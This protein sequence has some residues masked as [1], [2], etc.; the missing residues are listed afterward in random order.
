MELHRKRWT[1]ERQYGGLLGDEMAIV[2]CRYDMI[3]ILIVCFILL[4]PSKLWWSEEMED[5]GSRGKLTMP[6]VLAA[7]DRAKYISKIWHW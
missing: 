4:L 2:Y 6:N 5:R 3:P 7:M 1:D